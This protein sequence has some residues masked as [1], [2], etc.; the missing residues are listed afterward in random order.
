MQSLLELAPLIAFFIAYSLGG[1]YVATSVLMVAMALL[2]AVDYLRNRR[3][4]T[5]H[6]ISAVLVFAFG[7][8]TLI[9]HDQRFIQW[10]P[11]VFFWMVS[12]ALL[13]SM[14]IGRQPLVQRLMGHILEGQAHV[15]EGTWR[16]LNLLWVVFYSLLG[17]LNLLVAFNTSEA[18]WV[19]FKVIGLTAATFVFTGAQLF[20]LMRRAPAPSAST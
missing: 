4:S 3:V 20:W 11:T 12:I 6:A 15:S 10:K 2:L 8:A 5:M 19:K 16:R 1:I 14:W 7:A 13:G 9:L 17:G 18:T